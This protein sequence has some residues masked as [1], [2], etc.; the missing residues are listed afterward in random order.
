MM[1]VL[2]VDVSVFTDIPRSSTGAVV[3]FRQYPQLRESLSVEST[4]TCP[5]VS[6]SS[7]Q[8]LDHEKLSASGR[9]TAEPK[10]PR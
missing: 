4:N 1:A 5:N 10:H 3:H 7:Q 9:C 2:T 8:L 6:P